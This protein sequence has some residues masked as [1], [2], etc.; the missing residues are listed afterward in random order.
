MVHGS[1]RYSTYSASS[2]T[3]ERLMRCQLVV[4]FFGQAL[5][6]IPRPGSA[7]VSHLPK[8]L[9]LTILGGW[10][11]I[12]DHR[13]PQDDPERCFESRWAGSVSVAEVTR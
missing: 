8:S 7:K 6:L 5:G 13:Q 9:T 12:R 2:N 11:K 10:R 1:N 3:H 4:S